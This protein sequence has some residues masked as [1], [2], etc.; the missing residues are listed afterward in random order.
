MRPATLLRGAA[1]VAVFLG[2]AELLGRAGLVDPDTLPLASRVLGRAARL[3]ADGDF[4][5]D[6]GS[7]LAAWSAG[8]LL[9]VAIAVPIGL[10]IGTVP[11]IE[12][13]A[14]PFIELLRP[15]PSVAVIPLAMLLF[16]G[17]LDMKLAVIVFGATW[18]VLINTVYGLRE[19]D[20]L[21]KAT[22]RAFGF[23]PP[24]VLWWVSLP[25]TA[26]F[27]AT[28]I[29]IASGIALI[30]AISTELMAGG[31]EGIGVFVIEAGGSVDGTEMIIAA[32]VW[33]GVFGL[34]FDLLF[35]RAER[36]LFRWRA[37]RAGATS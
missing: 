17:N 15:I 36:R 27:I 33:A 11:A 35:T 22:L 6:V 26:P 23:R 2:A 3:A 32:A 21:A 29:R 4:R 8:L 5:A 14:R 19:V 16:P 25:S 31:A 34:L 30:L 13:V 28:G 7:T 10:L 24:A 20:P 37:A 18:P 9:T 12:T 1:G